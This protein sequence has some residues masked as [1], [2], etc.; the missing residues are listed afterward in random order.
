[1]E[2]YGNK[3]SLMKFVHRNTGYIIVGIILS[4]AIPIYLDWNSNID[5][6]EKWSCPMMSN[7]YVGNA[8][9]GDNPPYKNLDHIQKEKFDYIMVNEC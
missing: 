1:M 3:S 4:I 2:K 7:Y 9:A 6:F 8:T 5:F